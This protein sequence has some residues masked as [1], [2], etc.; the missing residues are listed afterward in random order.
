MDDESLA[1]FEKF[2]LTDHEIVKKIEDRLY[3][4]VKTKMV[5][6]GKEYG[7]GKQIRFVE[8]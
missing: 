8:A 2:F 1:E 5:Y 4:V 3:E 7:K 6:G